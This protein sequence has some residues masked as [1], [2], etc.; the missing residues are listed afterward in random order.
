M[1]FLVRL[2]LLHDVWKLLK[3]I[4]DPK[5][6]EWKN[7]HVILFV[8][9]TCH[10]VLLPLCIYLI[11]IVWPQCLLDADREDRAM[12]MVHFGV[13]L[14]SSIGILAVLYGL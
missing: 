11:A 6:H 14:A 8:D 3:Q 7:Q 4:N 9:K 5:Y 13:Y 2:P 12:L 1:H 10:I